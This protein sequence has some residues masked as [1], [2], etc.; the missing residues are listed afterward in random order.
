MARRRSTKISESFHEWIR[1]RAEE[2]INIAPDDEAALKK[3][4]N[5]ILS[6][7]FVEAARACVNR[8]HGVD[9]LIIAHAAEICAETNAAKELATKFSG[10]LAV[11]I[12]NAHGVQR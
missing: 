5:D 3:Y 2:I 12:S 9:S 1:A 10:Q 4:K 7:A 8:N 6:E 11:D